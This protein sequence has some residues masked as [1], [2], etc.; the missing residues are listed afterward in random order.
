[1]YAP[2]AQRVMDAMYTM[3]HERVGSMMVKDENGRVVG[4]VTQRDLLRC[5][6]RE[7][8]P[9][10]ARYDGV[11]EPRGWNERIS[12]VMTPSKDLVFLTP[13]DTLEDARALM[14]VSGKRHI[15]VLQG[16]D[17]I[18]VISPKDIARALHLERAEDISAKASYVATDMPRKGVPLNTRLLEP[19][20]D[21]RGTHTFALRSAVCN[22]PHPH[23]NSLG[24]DAFL[25]GPN[26]I[27]IADG[28]GS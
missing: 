20:E 21:E 6:V 10:F 5:I 23:K 27:G 14:A 22:L 3:I 15:P 2:L 8:E 1:M 13:R 26:M 7:G 9:P 28:V 18:G 25:L 11:S 4:F 24:E 19:S 12:N 17:L 16:S